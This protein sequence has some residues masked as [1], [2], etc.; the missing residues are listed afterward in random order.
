MFGFTNTAWFTGP[1]SK[2]LDGADV[3]FAVSAVIT[4]VLYP[5]MLKLFPEPRNVFRDYYDEDPNEVFHRQ[6]RAAARREPV[7]A[8]AVGA[9]AALEPVPSEGAR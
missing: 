6:R 4:A 8:S 9:D 7:A 3:G 5:I 2:W 1:G